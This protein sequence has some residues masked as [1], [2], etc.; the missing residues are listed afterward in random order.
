MNWKNLLGGSMRSFRRFKLRSFFMG[1][2]VAIGVAT[3]V[4]GGAVGKGLAD[5]LSDGLDR[6]IGP[7]SILV[8]SAELEM[9]DLEAIASRMEQVEAVSPFLMLGPQEIRYVGANRQAAVYGTSEN[10][11]YVWSRG[12]VEGRYLDGRDVDRAERVA[13]VGTKLKAALFGNG[14]AIG[15]EILIKS[16]P[17]EVIGV[18]EPIGID[19]HGEDRDMD[20]YVPITTAQRRVA[21]T[22]VIGNGKIVIADA[23]RMDDAADEIA[24]I[25]RERFNIPAGEPETF[26]I[27][28][29]EFA[30]AAADRAKK[31]LGVY[32]F[33]ASVVVLLVA[34]VVISSIMLVAMRERIA[35][36]GLRKAVGATSGAIATQFLCESTIVSLVSGLVGIGLGVGLATAVAR[37]YEI[38]LQMSPILVIVAVSASIVVGVVSGIVPARRASRLDPVAALR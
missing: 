9:A 20:V 13:L 32:V 34:A 17:F 2:G 16:V 4:A 5:R 23:D 14:D 10:G 21:N 36:I 29:S 30:G 37:M 24:V 28:T 1:V 35:E 8:G 15:A 6:M 38:P 3:L 18:L 27:Y 11:D 7:G 26:R 33:I 12:V 25:L 31:A 19:P 22:D